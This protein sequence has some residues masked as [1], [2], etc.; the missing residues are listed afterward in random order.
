M[1]VGWVPK[2]ERPR[3][4]DLARSQPVRLVSKVRLKS[5]PCV[6]DPG[7]GPVRSPQERRG[8]RH[9]WPGKWLSICKQQTQVS[10][11]KGDVTGVYAYETSAGSRWRFVYRQSDD[12]LTTRRGF[13]SRSTATTA[14]P[15]AVEEIRRGEVR[16]TPDTFDEF[17]AK[18]LETKRPYVTAGTPQDNTTHAGAH[19]CCRGSANS[20]SPRSTRTASATGSLSPDPPIDRG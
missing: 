13:R 4:P 20:A 1:F 8:Q 6:V 10:E 3:H 15:I 9:H 11:T 19:G 18:L 17:W 2:V 5:H 16:S 14:C 12:R 7:L